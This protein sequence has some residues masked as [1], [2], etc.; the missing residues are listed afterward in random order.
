MC[1][2]Y[3]EY[4]AYGRN[5]GIAEINATSTLST[6]KIK[7]SMLKYVYNVDDNIEKIY[8][9]SNAN[10]VHKRIKKSGQCIVWC[11]FIFMLDI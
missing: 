9:P 10:I 5:T 7:S 8:Y 3:Y 4:D 2:T 11:N 6:E 1:N